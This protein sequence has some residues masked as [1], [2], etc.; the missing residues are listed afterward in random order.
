MNSQNICTDTSQKKRQGWLICTLKGVQYHQTS[1]KNCKTQSG[2]ITHPFR[3]SKTKKSDITTCW[4]RSSQTEL[5][6]IVGNTQPPC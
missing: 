5:S 6:N 1:G 3:M 2:T 4:W